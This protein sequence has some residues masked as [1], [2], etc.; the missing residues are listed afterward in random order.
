MGT[1]ALLS[2]VTRDGLPVTAQWRHGDRAF[3]CAAR[4]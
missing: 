4:P 1:D 3:L 2:A